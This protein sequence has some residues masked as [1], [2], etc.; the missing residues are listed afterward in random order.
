MQLN[1][2]VAIRW[3]PVRLDVI[4]E[5][6]PCWVG[7]SRRTSEH[8]VDLRETG[9]ELNVTL[10]GFLEESRSRSEVD[11]VEDDVG[12]VKG[13]VRDDLG[14]SEELV[15]DRLLLLT[16]VEIRLKVSDL[17]LDPEVGAFSSSPV[18]STI[19][20]VH[21]TDEERRKIEAVLRRK[22]EDASVGFLFETSERNEP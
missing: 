10:L 18:G 8:R 19:V 21:V 12:G 5:I 13:L 2:R 1:V 3:R 9:I 20:A 15:G 22:E 11:L 17:A 7:K 16:L 14:P 4:V 6:E